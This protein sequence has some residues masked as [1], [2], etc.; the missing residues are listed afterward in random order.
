MSATMEIANTMNLSHRSSRVAQ[1]AA[2]FETQPDVWIDGRRLA[3]IAGA[4]AWRTRAAE[5]RRPPFNM[6]IVNR[7]RRV[8]VDGEKFVVSEYQFQQ[9]ERTREGAASGV[10]PSPAAM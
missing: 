2:F 6:R 5:L 4:Y 8:E 3:S 10:S 9:E 7:Q 1:L